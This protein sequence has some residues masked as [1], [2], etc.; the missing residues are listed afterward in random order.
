VTFAALNRVQQ[1]VLVVSLVMVALMIALSIVVAVNV[2][3]NRRSGPASHQ[4]HLPAVSLRLHRIVIGMFCI[5][6]L[7][8]LGPTIAQW[9]SAVS[10]AG[11]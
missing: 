3:A 10:R 4:A 1:S 5:L 6:L 7:S 11:Q 9:V 8:E 2:I